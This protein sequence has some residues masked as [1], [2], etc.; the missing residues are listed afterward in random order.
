[1]ISK[2]QVLI[3]KHIFVAAASCGLILGN[4]HLHQERQSQSLSQIL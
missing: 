1:M 2:T 3:D 4:Q